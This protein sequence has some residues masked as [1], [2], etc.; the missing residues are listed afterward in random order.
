[1]PRVTLQVLSPL[2]LLS[3][4]LSIERTASFLLFGF[5][6]T[7]PASL[8]NEINEL[9]L[10]STNLPAGTEVTLAFEYKN[11][12]LRYVILNG[13]NL[14]GYHHQRPRQGS[15]GQI[16]LTFETVDPPGSKSDPDGSS[17]SSSLGLHIQLGGEH[18]YQGALFL[19]D[20]LWTDLDEPRHTDPLDPVAAFNVSAKDGEEAAFAAYLPMQL[21]RRFN[22][23]EPWKIRA[24]LKTASDGKVHFIAGSMAGVSEEFGKDFVREV[25]IKEALSKVLTAFPQILLFLEPDYS[26]SSLVL[27]S[28]ILVSLPMTM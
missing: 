26:S 15:L 2:V 27:I 16:R 1:M 17:I 9:D 14:K 8:N 4:N 24:A 11:G 25:F 6:G 12:P 7:D 3:A 28:L 13:A 19:T 21:M 5:Y 23:A 22:I 10:G 20:L 18:D